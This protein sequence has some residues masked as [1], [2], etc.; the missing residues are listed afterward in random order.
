MGQRKAAA[1]A[2]G[3]FSRAKELEQ[4][5]S[6]SQP[7]PSMVLSTVGTIHVKVPAVH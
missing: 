6:Q 1:D 3:S 4:F 7:L 5:P 2:A